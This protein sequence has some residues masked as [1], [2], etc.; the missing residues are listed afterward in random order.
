MGLQLKVFSQISWLLTDP[1]KGVLAFVIVGRAKYLPP[2]PFSFPT[3]ATFLAT[4]KGFRN[5]PDSCTPI[6]TLALFVGLVVAFIREG[7]VDHSAPGSSTASVYVQEFVEVRKGV[8]Y[9]LGQTKS[10]VGVLERKVQ[11]GEEGDS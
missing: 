8:V 4:T 1:A 9:A 2:S 7:R 11:R 5:S 3:P 10:G 6:R